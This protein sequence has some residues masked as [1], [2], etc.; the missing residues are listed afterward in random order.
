MMTHSSAPSSFLK[1]SFGL[2]SY[3][4]SR[5]KKVIKSQKRVFYVSFWLIFQ[6]NAFKMTNLSNVDSFYRLG[7]LEKGLSKVLE[8]SE[9]QKVL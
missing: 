5:M 3:Q 1:S 4:K 8:W 2:I 9:K 6:A 7:A